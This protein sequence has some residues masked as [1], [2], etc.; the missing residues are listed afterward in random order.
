MSQIH[1]TGNGSTES[2]IDEVLGSGTNQEYL[3][4]INR[5]IELYE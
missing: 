3:E 5:D 1:A 2:V 4:A